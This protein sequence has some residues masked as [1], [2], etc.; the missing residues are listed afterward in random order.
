MITVRNAG[1][2][3]AQEVTVTDS[4]PSGMRFAEASPSVT[5]TAEGILTW[6]LGE[7]PPGD[8]RTINLQMIPERQGELGSVASVQFAAQASVRTV[9]NSPQTR[10]HR[11]LA[12]KASSATHN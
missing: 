2:S 12:Q 10:V 5:P 9:A 3:A 11:T 7:M 6:K 4:V 8:E 1:N